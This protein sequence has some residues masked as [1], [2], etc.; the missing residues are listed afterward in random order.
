MAQDSLNAI[1]YS[2]LNQINTTLGDESDLDIREVK[3]EI[4]KQRAL[5]LRNEYN[6]NART[7]A[8]DVI[9][10]LGCVELE[11]ADRSECCD[12]PAGCK[13]KRTVLTLPDTIEL[14][15]RT[16]YVRIGPIDKISKDYNLITVQEAPFWGNGRF[17][18]NEIAVIEMNDRLYFISHNQSKLDFLKYANVR[19]VFEDVEAAARFSHCNG[20]PCYK[21]S[22]KYYLTDWMEAYIKNIVVELLLKTKLQIVGDKTNDNKDN[23]T[24]EV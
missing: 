4:R 13:I 7:F 9:Q 2:V 12:V 21:D 3:R 14:H 19:G 10:D 18:K 6:K 20:T 5:F 16:G 17:N 15:N 11:L 8:D 22:D 23:T 24:K 1:A